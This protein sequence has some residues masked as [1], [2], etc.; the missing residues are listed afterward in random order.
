MGCGVVTCDVTE[1]VHLRLSAAPRSDEGDPCRAQLASPGRLTCS[2]ATVHVFGAQA[3]CH[4][5]WP[6]PGQ[7]LPDQQ[8][9][10]HRAAVR[11][12]YYCCCPPPTS[13]SS[14]LFPHLL[15]QCNTSPLPLC[16]QLPP[17]LC[18]AFPSSLSSFIFYFHTVSP[19]CPPLLS[20]SQH[21]QYYQESNDSSGR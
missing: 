7:R 3:V 9:I 16:L 11:Q 2:Q 21:S 17:F 19:H 14:P 1:W 10:Y 6:Q 20:L 18:P 8:G 13:P 15:L 5:A 12:G 4:Q